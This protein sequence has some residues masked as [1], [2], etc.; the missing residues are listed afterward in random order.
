MIYP[1]LSWLVP[2]YV[3]D[4]ISLNREQSSILEERL[5]H[6]LD[7]HCRTQLPVYARSLVRIA[8]ELEDPHHPVSFERLQFYTNQFKTYW[9]QLSQKIGP[10]M[11]DILATAS[12]E[13]LAEMFENIEKRN[14]KYKSEYVDIPLEELEK[15]RK[16]RLVKDLKQWISHLTPE[17]KQAVSDWSDQIKP[18]VADRLSNRKK[19]LTEFKNLLT[20]RRHHP[21][22]KEAFVTLLVNFDQIRAP[23]YQKK[24]EYNT[25]VTFRLLIKIDRSLNPT[26]RAYLLKRIGSLASDFEKLSCDPVRIKP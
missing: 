21:D 3:D 6:V 12:D 7:W 4:Y 23:D 20:K 26:Q 18:L 22:F 24:I 11:A 15:K 2:F 16:E 14:D 17:Q 25:E 13:Q 5:L 19:A 10:E 8:K 1:H 9:R